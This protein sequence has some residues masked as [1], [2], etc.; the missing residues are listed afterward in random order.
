[1]YTHRSKLNIL[2]ILC[3]VMSL[4]TLVV[5]AVT[6]RP[7]IHPPLCSSSPQEQKDRVPITSQSD[8]PAIISKVKKLEAVGATIIGDR[9][10]PAVRIEVRNNSDLGVTSFTVSN[11]IVAGGE[12]GITTNGL[13][14]PD[15]PHVVIEPHGTKTVDLPLANLDGKYPILIS[16]ATYTDSSEDGDKDMLDHMRLVRAHDKAEKEKRQKGGP[17]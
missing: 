13:T 9:S 10:N 16:G 17:Q 3:A 1:M 6:L 14:D 15:N 11:G 5:G 7:S 8:L 2:L 4:I 12:Y